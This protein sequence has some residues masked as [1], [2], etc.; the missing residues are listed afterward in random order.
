M[1]ELFKKINDFIRKLYK[2]PIKIIPLHEPVFAGN[3]KKYLN[4]CIDTTFVSSVGKFVDNFEV[5]IAQYTGAKY[6]VACVNG[7]SALHLA[8]NL[9][10]VEP[11]H[12]VITQ[13][14]TFIATANAITYCGAKPVFLDVDIDT[15]GL[16]PAKLEDWLKKNVTFKKSKQ[17]TRNAKR[18]MLVDQP[19]NKST[20]KIISGCI[21]MHTFG[22][23][24]KIDEI[25]EICNHFHIPVVEDASESLGSFYKGIH[26]GTYGKIG[27]LSFNGNKILT[28]GG[29]GMMLFN[30]EVLGKRAKHLSTQA[31]IPHTLEFSHDEIGYNYRMPNINA[32]LGLAQLEQLPLFL[33]SKRETAIAY[34]EFFS[35]LDI[36]FVTEPINCKSN[37][38]MNAIL[39][40][41]KTERDLFLKLT[42]NNGIMTRPAWKLMNT[43]IMFKD[44]QTDNLKNAIEISNRLVNIPSSVRV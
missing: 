36:E 24:C 16:C 26:T 4:E 5:K 42:N 39:L 38:W 15:M 43:L 31:K 34:K 27:V 22:H 18:E 20:N 3:E 6:A 28:T 10:G 1:Q 30:D 12:E 21:P 29:G 13:P 17:K 41:D 33:Q 25:I 7:T 40:K 37:Y 9:V 2:S 19:Y 14:L 11:G 23:P 35:E 44:C 8:L 32:A